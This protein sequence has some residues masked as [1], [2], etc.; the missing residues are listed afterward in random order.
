MSENGKPRQKGAES[1]SDADRPPSERQA[2]HRKTRQDKLQKKKKERIRWIVTA[3]LLSF[4][5]TAAIS[6]V[7]GEISALENVLLSFLLLIF[8]ILL[9]VLFD[10]I[11]LAVATANASP[12]HSMASRRLRAGKKAVWLINNSPK[13]SSFC[14]DIIGDICGVVSGAM[15]SVIA[16]RLFVGAGAFWLTL[17]LTSLIAALI[18]GLKAVGKHIAMENSEKIVLAVAK[19]LCGF[20]K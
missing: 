16:A 15:G 11:G 1:A 8:F 19:V 7:T 2:P 20:R 9:G 18:I 17:S 13:V 10:I 6:V 5:I 14:N 4:F 3:F 12:F